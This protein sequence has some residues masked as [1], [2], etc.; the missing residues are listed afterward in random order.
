MRRL[1]LTAALLVGLTAPAWA[2]FESGLAAYTRD[3]YETALWEFTGC[4]VKRKGISARQAAS[5]IR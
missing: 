5:T 1:V 3:D 2:D 4:G